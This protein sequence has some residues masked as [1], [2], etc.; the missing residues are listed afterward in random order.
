[1][2]T[3]HRW[4]GRE[5]SVLRAA[6]RLSIRGYAE[7]LGIGV[8]T[9]TKWQA[10]GQ[11]M[12]LRPAMQSVLD[13]ALE[14]SSNEVKARFESILSANAVTDTPAPEAVSQPLAQTNGLL[15]LSTSEWKRES[16]EALSAFLFNTQELTADA[17]I[18]LSHEWRAIDPP[19]VVELRTGRRV[20]TRLA[21]LVTE[22]A[23]VLRHMDD[24]LGGGDMHDLVRRELRVTVHMVREAS[25]SEKNGRLL[26]SAVGELAQLAGWVASDAG[27]H[28]QAERYYLGGATA[29][30]AAKDEPL[31]GNLLSSL[32]YQVANVGDPREAVLLAS[33]AY[34]GAEAHATATTRALLLE[35]VAWANARFGDTR[36]TDH[37]LGG[38]NETFAD[39]DPTQDPAWVYWLNRE[40]IDVMAG[41]CFTQLKRPK[42]AIDLLKHAVSQY[43]DTH[44]REM[45]LYL[46]WLAEAHIYAGNIE[47]AATIASRALELSAEVTSS[48]GVERIKVV[49]GLLVPYRG[50]AAVEEFEERALEV[51]DRSACH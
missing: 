48:R 15:P 51:V 20:G 39:S 45:A 26:L 13:T 35:R 44:T 7:H 31:A 8:R 10:R 40:E 3:V 27:L 34:N 33:S 30:H 12:I 43:D 23:D 5:A 49:R 47:K 50:N 17:A 4:T 38:V 46:S 37:A 22:R 25:Y 11:D 29:A 16:T 28:T 18:R 19:Q 14:R 24:F 32:A 21:Q 42:P 2:T 9:V 36:A 41:R 6:L 1:M